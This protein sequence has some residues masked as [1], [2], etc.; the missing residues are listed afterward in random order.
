MTKPLSLDLRNRLI[1]AVEQGTSCRSAAARFSVAASTAIK[2]AQNWRKTGTS[3]P[4][5]QGGDRRSGPI[6]AHA[7]EILSLVA[8]RV[9][10]TLAEI[11]A[12]LEQA[13][14]KRFAPSVVWRFL[15]RHGQ[16]FK[17]NRAR[18]RTRTPR[19]RGAKKGMAR[20]AAWP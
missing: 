13:H 16:T 5:P 17:K 4:R 20:N 15:D 12:H 18:Q 3:A 10:I 9:D 6:E 14:G 2:L 7:D 11:A 8:V 1:E 19:R